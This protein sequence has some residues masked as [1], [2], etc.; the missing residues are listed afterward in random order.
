MQIL[1]PVIRSYRGGRVADQIPL[2]LRSAFIQQFCRK[3]SSD[4]A[5]K[6]YLV[7]S[8]LINCHSARDSSS[9]TFSA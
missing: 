5:I 7:L 1:D 3:P 9:S 8:D 4:L 6:A 2:H